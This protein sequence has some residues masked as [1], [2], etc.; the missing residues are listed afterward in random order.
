MHVYCSIVFAF[1]SREQCQ[2]REFIAFLEE[3]VRGFRRES[4]KD[5]NHRLW[6]FSAIQAKLCLIILNNPSDW[7]Y[8]K[9]NNEIWTIFCKKRCKI[10]GKR[11]L[12]VKKFLEF[13]VFK[14]KFDNIEI[15]VFTIFC[16]IYYITILLPK[17]L[18]YYQ[19]NNKNNKNIYIRIYR[20]YK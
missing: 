10:A 1:S 5:I 19:L 11:N 2:E 9:R 3:N 13:A 17:L 4:W 6:W 14:N 18:Y 20:I 15:F 8:F 7:I 16:T 12:K